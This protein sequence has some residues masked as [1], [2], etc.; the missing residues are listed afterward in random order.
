MLGDLPD[1]EGV[2][3]ASGKKLPEYNV[4]EQY[5]ISVEEAP[6]GAFSQ[7]DPT[8]GGRMNIKNNFHSSDVNEVPLQ[9][10]YEAANCRLFYTPV[11]V[12][13]IANLWERVA[14]V[15]WNGGK[16]IPGSSINSDNTLPK[17][18]YDTIPV[19]PSAAPNVTMNSS[20]PR[21]VTSTSGQGS[22]GGN[23]TSTSKPSPNG[24]A[25]TGLNM[26]LLV[27]VLGAALM[28]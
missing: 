10:T 4:P 18:P 23:G 25:S 26:A 15:T 22:S 17:G 5:N 21:L 7:F 14:N 28:T 9:F 6:L 3:A 20:P 12:F 13:E 27:G 19:G 16:C 8:L 2:Y 11:D 1:L 24:A